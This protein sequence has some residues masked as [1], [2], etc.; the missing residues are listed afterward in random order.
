MGTK[1]TFLGYYGE[2]LLNSGFD[3]REMI[4]NHA[5]RLL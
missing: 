2:E 3:L 1:V 4:A 5:R